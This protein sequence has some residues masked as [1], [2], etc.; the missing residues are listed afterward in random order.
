[1]K[2]RVK[3][4][5]FDRKVDTGEKI[6][7]LLDPSQ[8]RRPGVAAKRVN[9]DFPEWMVQSIDAHVAIDPAVHGIGKT[10]GEHPMIVEHLHNA[11]QRTAP[12]NRCRR[13][14]SRESSRRHS[15]PCRA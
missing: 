2:A 9:V 11:R 12:R 6:T 4:A 10:S 15:L 5:T 7:D 14:E 8:A 3:A 1:M 13:T